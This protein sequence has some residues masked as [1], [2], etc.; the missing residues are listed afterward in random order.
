MTKWY[1]DLKAD[2]K[3]SVVTFLWPKYC[4]CPSRAINARTKVCL[5]NAVICAKQLCMFI[6]RYIMFFVYLFRSPRDATLARYLLS[7]CVC[8]SLSVSVTSRYCIETTRRIELDFSIQDSFRLSYTQYYREIWVS[9]KL[10]VFPSGTQGCKR[11]LWEN[12]Q[13]GVRRSYFRTN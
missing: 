13:N 2:C 10:K 5:T 6:S 1:M 4:H 8:S 7:S 11:N 3:N 9:P 12:R